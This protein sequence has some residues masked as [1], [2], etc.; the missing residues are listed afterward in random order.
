MRRILGFL[1]ALCALTLF[2][3][4]WVSAQ[5][6]CDPFIIH[7]GESSGSN[8]PGIAGGFVSTQDL[9]PIIGKKTWLMFEYQL[10]KGYNLIVLINN[11]QFGLLRG[12]DGA[13]HQ[14]VIL[15]DSRVLKGLSD[16]VT[17][18]SVPLLGQKMGWM[19]WR[20]VVIHAYPAAPVNL[21][22]IRVAFHSHSTFS[23]GSETLAE[24]AAKAKSLWYDAMV[25]FE[26][27]E[28]ID[29]TKKA[30]YGFVLGKKVAVGYSNYVAEC[31]RLSTPS[32]LVPP[33][34]EIDTTWNPEPGVVEHSHTT[35][36]PWPGTTSDSVIDG[37]SG[38]LSG[39][40]AVL[41]RA[42]QMGMVTGAAHSELIATKV[43]AV[44]LWEWQR[45]RYDFRNEKWISPQLLGMF[46]CETTDQ[47]A[48]IVGRY[49]QGQNAFL[50]PYTPYSD[51]DSHGW[52]DVKDKERWQRV[53]YALVPSLTTASLSNAMGSGY[54]M[55]FA[56]GFVPKSMS[57]APGPRHWVCKTPSFSFSFVFW[58]W[59]QP[60]KV[61]GAPIATKMRLYR[62][63][64]PV[65]GSEISIKKGQASISYSFVDRSAIIGEHRY[66]LVTDNCLVTA[67][68]WVDVVNFNL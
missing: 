23:D 35:A 33:G 48:S 57:A 56:Q 13:W 12:V 28:Q 30:W 65:S 24:R 63:G 39:T 41:L 49:H 8:A 60:G 53:T 55:A 50:V 3:S 54:T 45:F 44:P 29:K 68:I 61:V 9:R 43:G 15:F 21:F 31:N 22:W 58:S 17:V 6:P 32:F 51:N 47:Q 36:F 14:A 4:A 62:D 66:D 20:N 59:D 11:R 40:T 18:S 26:H 67:P 52:L 10:P 37:L 5:V 7:R 38:K 1:L 16:T 46:G 27:A 19:A 34:V 42:M 2:F 64:A 25:P